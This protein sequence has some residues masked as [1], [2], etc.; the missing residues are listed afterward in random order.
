MGWTYTH[1]KENEKIVDFFK[2]EFESFTGLRQVNILDCSVKNR[3]AYIALADTREGKT[4]VRAVVCLL[5]YSPKD[6]HNFGYKDMS[7]EMGP[8]AYDCPK[9]ILDLLSP[10][11]DENALKW[12]ASCREMLKKTL[13]AGDKVRFKQ[14][15]TFSRSGLILNEFVYVKGS[16]FAAPQVAA[17]GGRF[18]ITNW[19]QR[20]FNKV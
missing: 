13:K 10:T 5:D 19:K 4:E 11:T 18:R 3:V 6:Y 8:Y 9:K 15:L 14:A 17:Y 2:R 16:V 12:R 7:E 20:E 1:K